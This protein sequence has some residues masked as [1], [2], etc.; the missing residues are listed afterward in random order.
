M[1]FHSY[2]SL[3]EG[4]HQFMK[5]MTNRDG[6]PGVW[7]YVIYVMSLN[8]GNLGPID[9]KILTGRMMRDNIQGL[10]HGASGMM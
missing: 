7:W 6:Y 5:L 1:I 3:P 8:M 10:F 2:G 4:S 9:G